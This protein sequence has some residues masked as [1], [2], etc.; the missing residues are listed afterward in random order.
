MGDLRVALDMT[1]AIAGNTGV[2]RYATEVRRV[3]EARDEVELVPFAIGR[4]RNIDAGKRIKTPLRLMQQSWKRLGQPTL[5]RLV[6]PADVVHS[7]DLTAPPAS[8]PVVMT[9]HDVLPLVLPHLYGDR[10]IEASRAHV[11]SAKRADALVAT[12]RTTA[13]NIA[14]VTGIDRARIRVAY[15][16]HRVPLDRDVPPPVAGPYLLAVGAITPRKGFELAVRALE[17]LDPEVRLVLAGPRG[18][19]ADHFDE[20]L[21]RSP[22]RDRV[23]TAGR[24]SD[25]DLDAF[26]KH[27]ALLVHPSEAEGFGIPVIEAMAYGLPVVARRIPSLE[28]I[29]G[30][31]IDFF[32]RGDPKL[33]A[34]HVTRLL[35]DEERRQS[36]AR[37]GVDLAG[38]YTWEQMTDDLIGIWTEIAG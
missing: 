24:V 17:H 5:E 21:A 33:L 38:R 12:C 20:V 4:G 28:E 22:S 27:A 6:G 13:D 9:M 1:P 23:I 37:R 11:E 25:H 34:D 2:A 16:G 8:C 32:D 29:G 30:D 19:R 36:L 31:A 15:P 7:V 10:Y 35:A 3:A 14:E 18:W 26:F